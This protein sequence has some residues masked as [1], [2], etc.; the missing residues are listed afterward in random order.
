MSLTSDGGGEDGGIIGELRRRVRELEQRCDVE[1][2]QAELA[3]REKATVKG[4]LDQLQEQ[5]TQN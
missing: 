1:R 2:R 3:T 4:R 5:V